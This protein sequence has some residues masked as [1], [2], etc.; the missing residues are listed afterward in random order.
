MY[1][2]LL[3]PATVRNFQEPWKTIPLPHEECVLEET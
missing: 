2:L 3:I 1:H